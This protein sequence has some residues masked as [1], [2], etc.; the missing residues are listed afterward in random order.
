MLKIFITVG[1]DD[2]R[3]RHVAGLLLGFILL[4]FRQ[5]IVDFVQLLTGQNLWDPSIRFLTEL[6]SQADPV[7]IAAI[8]VHGAGLQL[9]RHALSG[10]QGG[11]HRSGAGAAL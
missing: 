7:E 4:Y 5:P 1:F 8:V 2:R 9:P 10:V 6:P 11:E 3:A